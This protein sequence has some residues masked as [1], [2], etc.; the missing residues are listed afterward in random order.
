MCVCMCVWGGWSVA[1]G[2]SFLESLG[3]G[4]LASQ[5]PGIG[6][7]T[8]RPT[9]QVRT[10]QHWAPWP[11]HCGHREQ[12]SAVTGLK[13]TDH[14]WSISSGHPFAFCPHLDLATRGL[15]LQQWVIPPP[16][17]VFTYCQWFSQTSVLTKRRRNTNMATLCFIGSISHSDLDLY[18]LS[19]QERFDLLKGNES[20]LNQSPA[21]S[22]DPST[23]KVLGP[24]SSRPL[25]HRQ[26]ITSL[27]V[28]AARE[29]KE[30]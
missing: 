25:S 21:S 11:W 30:Q 20:L 18:Y 26:N 13:E 10:G 19:C 15:L 12:P 14:V 29:G 22:L 9:H 1:E 5:S 24:G 7:T 6:D 23:V 4:V 17:L 27:E 2:P 8:Y 3:A 16:P 28:L